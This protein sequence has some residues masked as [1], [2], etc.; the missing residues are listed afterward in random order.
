ME[1]VTPL[2]LKV[3]PWA[4][5]V[6][7]HKSFVSYLSHKKTILR[8]FTSSRG[9]HYA[10]LNTLPISLYIVYYVFKAQRVF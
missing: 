2:L 9:L 4:M 7:Y 1:L 10:I 5:A 6:A 8:K 3:C